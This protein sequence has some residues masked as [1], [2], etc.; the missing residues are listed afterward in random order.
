MASEKFIVILLIVAIV[1]SIISIAV[2]LSGV[3]SRMVPVVKI[4]NEEGP[5]DTERGLVTIVITPQAVPPATE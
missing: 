1:L 5:P 3:N 2:T 4:Q